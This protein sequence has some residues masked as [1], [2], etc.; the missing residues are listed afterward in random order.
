[1]RA[2]TFLRRLRYDQS[3]AS[4]VEF[5]IVMPVFLILTTGA[6]DL[7][8]TVYTKSVLEGAVQKAA[9]DSSLES[10]AD[11]TRQTAIDQALKDTVLQIQPFATV[12][13]TRKSFKDFSTAKSSK[14]TFVD[15]DKNGTC[16]HGE[17]YVD[18]N[19]SGAWDTDSGK[20][21]QG[22]AKD[23]TI[24]TATMTYQRLLPTM[25][26][27]GMSRDVTMSARNVIANQPYSDQ[28]AAPTGNCT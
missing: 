10:G 1:M 22:G 6:L 3:G 7:G 12:Q 18:S 20:D 13:I 14:E 19:K 5:A 21:G 11:T 25:T 27:L 26:L 24:Y 23:I 9:R 8:H 16:D 17:T 28:I 4:V 15:A 2:R